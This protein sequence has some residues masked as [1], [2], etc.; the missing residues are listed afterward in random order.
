[1]EGLE[2]EEGK[3]TASPKLPLVCQLV[4]PKMRGPCVLSPHRVVA[5]TRLQ[6]VSLDR[7]GKRAVSGQ[8]SQR[9][10]VRRQAIQDSSI[11]N[12]EQ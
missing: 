9:H 2:D 5:S 8:S 10:D 6:Q 12:P 7:C 3:H 1:M 4:H 11:P